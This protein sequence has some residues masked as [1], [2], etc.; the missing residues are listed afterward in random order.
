MQEK[1]EKKIAPAGAVL[2]VYWSY[3]K[4]AWPLLSIIILL[5]IVLQVAN[6]AA[7]LFL[8]EFFNTLTLNK[9]SEAVV[10]TLVGTLGLVFLMWLLNWAATRAQD[11][12][13]IFYGARV[14]ETSTSTR[15][16]I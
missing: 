3:A 9:P 15:S 8:R 2:T 14:M 7:P 1:D 6:L 11:V 12:A 5:S 13:N 10:G 16:N 4:K